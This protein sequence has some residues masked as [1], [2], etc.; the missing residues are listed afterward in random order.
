MSDLRPR[1]VDITLGGK[2]YGL[3]FTLNVIDEIQDKTGQP[4]SD[5]IDALEDKTKQ[6]KTLKMMLALMINEYIDEYMPGEKYVTEKY[7]GRQIGTSGIAE[8]V[9][10]IVST[11]IASYPEEGD[12]P[13]VKSE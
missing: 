4:I 9:D 8:M 13:N 12:S 6:F 1:P 10:K 2:E 3:L 7:V 5:I 11:L